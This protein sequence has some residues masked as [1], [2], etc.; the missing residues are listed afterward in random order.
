MK[1]FSSLQ[2]FRVL[3]AA[4]IV[5]AFFFFPNGWKALAAFRAVQGLSNPQRRFLQKGDWYR[6]VLSLGNQIPLNATIRLVSPAPPWYLAYYLYPRL[7][8]R[9]SE[10]L[11]DEGRVRKRHPGD[12]VLVYSE[13]PP[14]VKIRPPLTPGHS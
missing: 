1:R 11:A 2:P 6:V 4:C 13:T 9:G 5:N 12:W 14:Q 7:L 10:V 8:K 3:W